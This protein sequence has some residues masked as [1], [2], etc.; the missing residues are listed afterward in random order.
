VLKKC[1]GL[2]WN[3]WFL[4]AKKLTRTYR[5]INVTMKMNFITLQDV[6][7]FP[8]MDEFLKEFISYVIALLID[9][10]FKYD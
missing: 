1:D 5:L 7:L 8:L 4:V 2:Y 10:F 6:N 9:F 3:P